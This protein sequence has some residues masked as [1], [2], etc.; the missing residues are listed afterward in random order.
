MSEEGRKSETTEHE[1]SEEEHE[2]SEKHR[3]SVTIRDASAR[4]AAAL[5]P[6]SV[7]QVSQFHRRSLI[8]PAKEAY[9]GKEA[10]N[11]ALNNS[12]RSKQLYWGIYR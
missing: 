6:S 8:P 2:L 4:G 1:K 12:S 3:K 9:S 10:E 11:T 5:R 7:L